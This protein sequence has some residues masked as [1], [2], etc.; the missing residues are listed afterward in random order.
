MIVNEIEKDITIEDVSKEVKLSQSTLSVHFKQL[1]D[2]GFIKTAVVVE[3]KCRNVFR[4][5][6]PATEHLVHLLEYVLSKIELKIDD[7]SSNHPFYSK[8]ISVHDWNRYFE[9]TRC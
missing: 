4:G 8:Q 3:K 2:S 9:V 6:K 7:R 1:H 5:N